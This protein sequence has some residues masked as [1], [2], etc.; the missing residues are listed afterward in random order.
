MGLAY[1]AQGK[2]DDAA[3]S[4]ETASKLQPMHGEAWYRLG[5]ESHLAQRPQRVAQVVE[6]LKA[7]DPRRANQLIRDTGRDDLAHLFTE[8]PF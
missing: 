1:A 3:D 6:K 7:F 4:F 5:M 8:I 2:H